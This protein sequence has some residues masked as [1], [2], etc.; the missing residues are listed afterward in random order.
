MRRA[1]VVCDRAWAEVAKAAVVV[2][3]QKKKEKEEADAQLQDAVA[4][5]EAA[6]VVEYA[7]NFSRVVEN[8]LTKAGGPDED[9]P[10]LV[11]AEDTT[12]SNLEAQLVAGVGGGFEGALG[13]AEQTVAE[14]KKTVATMQGL[15]AGGV[16]QMEVE[17]LEEVLAGRVEAASARM[18]GE[19]ERA[20]GLGKAAV[21]IRDNYLAQRKEL[22]AAIARMGA[23]QEEETNGSTGLHWRC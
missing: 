17:G 15:V 23:K 22:D 19:R 14:V 7:R 11:D 8:S 21:G 20:I 18:K 16:D 4:L 2:K 3:D 10:P 12:G 9:L 5:S 13:A 6:L 1:A